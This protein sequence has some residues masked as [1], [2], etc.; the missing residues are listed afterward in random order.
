MNRKIVSTTLRMAV[1]S[2]AIL[3]LASCNDFLNDIPK[4]QKVP[5]TWADYNAFIMSNTFPYF[6]M[7]Q[8]F[9]LTGDLYCSPNK[10]NSDELLR[11]HYFWDENQDRKLINS[12]DK[13]AYY[14]AYEALFYW[15]L[16]IEYGPEATE[17]TQQQRD[18]LVAQARVLRAM[19]YFYVTNYYAA[20]YTKEN[21]HLMSVPLITSSSVEAKSPQVSLET[22]YKF[23]LED[24]HQAL[25]A[26]PKTGETIV[27]PT[28]AA[29]YGMLARVYLTMGNYTEAL[30]YAS[31]SLEENSALYNWIQFYND[32]INRFTN[33][34]DYTQACKS[35]PEKVNVENNVFH[36]SSMGFWG[37]ISGTGYAITVERAEKFEKGDTRLLTHWKKK[38]SSKL[39]QYFYGIYALE[40]NK[41]GIRSAEMY[42]IK[43]ECLARLGGDANLK[44]AMSLV[45]QVRKTRIF[46]EFYQDWTAA[47]VQEA[48]RKIMADKAN[49]FIQSQIVFCDYRRLNTDPE[50]AV[51]LTKT[52][53]GKE[54]QL[55]PDSHLWIMPFPL[56]VINNPGNGTIVQNVEK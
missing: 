45:N 7:D 56:E 21:S 25:D 18:M 22:M 11:T 16:I 19:T 48:V 50:Y 33:P 32:D 52:V 24:L 5:K 15:N 30:K 53:D 14:S 9:C 38:V 40:P 29:G 8:L 41:G 47:S 1:L 46:P 6:E 43:A 10:L 26:L 35:D 27:H 17:C 13:S 44:E 23:I 36:L 55:R 49:E 42:Y 37:G 31:L 2:A 34:D 54:Y 51:T 4:G 20:P 39:G 12:G 28:L 3:F